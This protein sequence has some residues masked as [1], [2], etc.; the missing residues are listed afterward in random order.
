MARTSIKDRAIY[1]VQVLER[2]FDI[3]D[4]LAAHD[5]ELALAELSQRLHLHRS[6]VH[7]LLVVL[8]GSRYVE[9][10]AST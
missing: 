3:L 6:T 4:A 1:R 10:S 2:A 5:A 9:K 7:R 8:E